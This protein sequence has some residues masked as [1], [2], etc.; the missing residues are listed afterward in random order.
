MSK[1]NKAIFDRMVVSGEFRKNPASVVNEASGALLVTTKGK[2]SF[3]C[4]QA[5]EYEYIYEEA[6]KAGFDIEGAFNRFKEQCD[7]HKEG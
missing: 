3:Y 7:E 4:I 5:K 6:K 1:V 2:P